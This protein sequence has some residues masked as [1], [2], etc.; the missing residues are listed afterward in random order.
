[1]AALAVELLDQ[2]AATAALVD[3]SLALAVRAALSSV[4]A[5]VA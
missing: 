5:T 4:T 2:L 1:L 3:T